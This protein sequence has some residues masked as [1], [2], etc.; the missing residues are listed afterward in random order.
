MIVT[1][2]SVTY[3]EKARKQLSRANISSKIVKVDAQK[4][5]RGCTYGISF[6]DSLQLSAI[7]VLRNSDIPYESYPYIEKKH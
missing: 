1:L 3:A 4:T 6:D 7:M 5:E 2:P